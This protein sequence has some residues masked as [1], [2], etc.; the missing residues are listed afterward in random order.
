[1]RQRALQTVLLVHAIEQADLPGDALSISDRTDASREALDGRPPPAATA[2]AASIN[3]ESMRFLVRR[4]NTLV[5]RLRVRSPGVDRVLA[6]ATGSPGLGRAILLLAFAF[7]VVIAFADGGRIDIF[8]YPLIGLVIWN[9]VVYVI[10]IARLFASS[11]AA[12]PNDAAR[13][14]PAVSRDGFIRRWLAGLYGNGVH[15]RIDRLITHSIGFNAPLAPGLRR[16]AADWREVGR[17]MFRLRV[18]RLLHLAA[19]FA[20]V[21]LAAGYEF[22]GRFLRQAAG[23]GNTIF[24]PTS[25][26]AALVTVYG[27]ASAILRLPIPSA[28]DLQTLAWTGAASGGGPAGPWLVLIDCTALIYIV[29]PRLIAVIV[30]TMG[31]WHR[32]ARSKP[33]PTLSA[34]LAA[35]LR[36]VSPPPAPPEARPQAGP[37]AGSG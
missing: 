12:V 23:W 13:A 20:A 24:G 22:R 28:H 34:Y 15:A 9:L 32:A 18:A 35:L 6:A 36:A 27:A 8:A 19:V 16:F 31:L 11:P 2:A 10:L 33:P 17:P 21:G 37:D 29:V 30:T 26:H 14:P 5:A 4:A 7:G 25:A 1:M 3:R